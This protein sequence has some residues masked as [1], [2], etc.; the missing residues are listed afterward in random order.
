MLR[1][2]S[3]I[4]D[5]SVSQT[6]LASSRSIIFSCDVLAT[7]GIYFVPKFFF[8]GDSVLSRPWL[9]RRF[10]TG[11]PA[12]REHQ[13]EAISEN[14]RPSVQAIVSAHRARYS[15]ER[16]TSEN[17]T[18]EDDD[19]SHSKSRG[20]SFTRNISLRPSTIAKESAVLDV[21]SEEEEVGLDEDA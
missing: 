4:I 9:K 20:N 17:S 10:A 3:Y 14:G 15:L 21:V 2:L 12:G 8:I 6:D 5:D 16:E 18:T 13:N 1:A 19:D 11:Q 7:I